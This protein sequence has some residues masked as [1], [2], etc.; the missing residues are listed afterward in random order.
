MTR[1]SAVLLLNEIFAHGDVGHLIL[2]DDDE[3]DLTTAVSTGM[4][5]KKLDQ[6]HKDLNHFIAD[7]TMPWHGKLQN[8]DLRQR[9]SDPLTI[10]F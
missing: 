1:E 3:G 7:K 4:K 9:R 8:L 2:V 6:I 10:Y 5:E